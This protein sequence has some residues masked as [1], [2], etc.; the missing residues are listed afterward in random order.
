MIKWKGNSHPFIDQAIKVID[1]PDIIPKQLAPNSNLKVEWK[2]KCGQNFIR[3]LH[4]AAKYGVRCRT[5]SNISSSRLE[6]EIAALLKAYLLN[7]SVEQYYNHKDYNKIVDLYIKEL[8]CAIE[9]D[10]YHSHY[11]KNEVDLYITKK[12]KE[13]YSKVLRIRD[14]K[15][16]YIAGS[17]TLVGNPREAKNWVAT[18]L[19]TSLLEPFVKTISEKEIYEALAQGNSLWDAKRFLLK[20]P[21]QT[22]PK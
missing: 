2:C 22:T 15:L 4:H 18:I 6:Y 5:C 11:K 7:L 9:I 13:N 20:T 16:P 1:H 21:P 14:P 19:K 10:P 17:I 3:P 8:D 12:L